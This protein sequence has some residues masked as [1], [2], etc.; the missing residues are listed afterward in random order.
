MWNK[1]MLTSTFYAFF[2]SDRRSVIAF[3][4]VG[5]LTALFNFS[6]FTLAWQIFHVDYQIAV[7]FSYVSALFFHFFM[8]RNITFRRSEERLAPQVTKYAFMA[9]MNYLTT[10]VVVEVVV[11]VLLLSPY[12]GVL[13]AIGVTVVSGYFMSKF[14]V[15]KIG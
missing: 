9:M 15:F 7:T 5:A 12:F 2:S 1:R 10:L 6:L 4:M 14:W 11:N 13:I 3:L 8:N